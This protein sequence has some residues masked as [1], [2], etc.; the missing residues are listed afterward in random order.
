MNICFRHVNLCT[1]EPTSSYSVADTSFSPTFSTVSSVFV[2]SLPHL[3]THRRIW[4]LTI[5]M[6]PFRTTTTL[7]F[8]TNSFCA[9]VRERVTWPDASPHLTSKNGDPFPV[10]TAEV[11]LMILTTR[12]KPFEFGLRDPIF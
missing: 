2:S 7:S 3:S 5:L 12:F 9:S 1:Q 8:G 6:L 11:S 4:P 10:S